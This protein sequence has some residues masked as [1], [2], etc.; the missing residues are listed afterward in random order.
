MSTD[1]QVLRAERHTEIGEII[2][3]QAELLIER[4]QHRALEEQP[5]A[6]AAH[7]QELH[8]H[9]PAFLLALGRQLAESEI[10]ARPHCVLAVA[11]GEQ[12]WKAGWSLAEVVRD[13]Q[14][15]RLVILDRLDELLDRPLEVREAMAV[16][17]A[18]D[19]AIAAATVTFAAW[20]EDLLRQ[21]DRR[22]SEFLSSMSHEIRTPMTAILGFAEI[23]LAGAEGE[24]RESLQ[25]IQRNGQ[26]LLEII[27]DI[28]DLSKIEAGK[29]DVERTACSPRQLA[30]EV[31]ALFQGR[32]EQKGLRLELRSAAEVPEAILTDCTRLRQILVNLV[33]NAVKFTQRGSIHVA[34]SYDIR[35]GGRLIVEV[36]DSGP[37]MDA[38]QA[39]RV[40]E[41]F[42][43]LHSPNG[44]QAEGTGLGLTISKRLAVL[45]GGDIEVDSRPGDGSVFRLTIAAPAATAPVQIL[46]PPSAFSAANDGAPLAG[47]RVLV[48]DDRRDNQLLIS[49]ILEKAGAGTSIAEDGERAIAAVAAAERAGRPFDVILLDMRMPLV[50]GYEAAARIRETGCRTPIIALTASAMKGDR[51]KCL[52]AGC[53]D[54]LVKP[55][56]HQQLT[57]MVVRHRG[58]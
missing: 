44:G 23:G 31:V 2:A 56:H 18:L 40:F 50:D 36:R 41:P 32:A 3:S 57:D 43:Q 45:L 16:G 13:Y 58:R 17:L 21:A 27:N 54:Y 7:R 55:V 42:A 14:I 20:Q 52:A 29:T 5:N 51:E 11:H 48:A 38:A 10:G 30:A 37:G 9:L 33:G 47:C 24:L 53:D 8:D 22:K 1:P 46:F 28:L 6:A 35:D 25:T 49:R 39:E 15:L 19:E 4:W 12:R 34:L 26:Y